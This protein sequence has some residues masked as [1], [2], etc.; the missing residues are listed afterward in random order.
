MHYVAVSGTS[1][2]V[3]PGHYSDSWQ[4]DKNADLAYGSFTIPPVYNRT[5]SV[6]SAIAGMCAALCL[7]SA[8]F[9]VHDI[10]LR[11]SGRLGSQQLVVASAAFTR[12]GKILVKPDGNIPLQVMSTN[13]SMREILRE[14]DIRS[15]TFSWIYSLTWD[16]SECSIDTS[17]KNRRLK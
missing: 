9:A 17:R 8:G 4:T 5:K 6:F 13:S 12:D 3:R 2:T 11:K 10:M 14:L 15:T 16:W 1:W 7:L